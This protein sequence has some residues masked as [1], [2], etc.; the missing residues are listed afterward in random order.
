[1]AGHSLSLAYV[2][3]VMKNFMV[4]IRAKVFVETIKSGLGF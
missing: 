4:S 1:M 3:N 2:E